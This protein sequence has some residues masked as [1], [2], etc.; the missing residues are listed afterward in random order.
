MGRRG[1]AMKKNMGICIAYSVCFPF[2]AYCM[3]DHIPKINPNNPQTVIQITNEP[4]V[5][6]I[7]QQKKKPSPVPAIVIASKDSP[8]SSSRNLMK[9]RVTSNKELEHHIKK[10]QD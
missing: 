9:K 10:A 7:T 5:A 8:G 3:D 1:Y 4:I 2:M 6:D